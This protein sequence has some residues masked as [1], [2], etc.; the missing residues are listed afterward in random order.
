M[1]GR[2]IVRSEALSADDGE[3]E[4]LRLM[5][6]H[7]TQEALALFDARTKVLLHA[8]PRYVDLVQ[9]A[10]D[11]PRG[12]ILGRSWDELSPMGRE[13]GAL[14]V[15]ACE[16]GRPEHR[17]ELRVESPRGETFWDC[18]LIPIQTREG[19][20]PA[21]VRYIVVSAVEVT[22]QVETRERLGE[23]DRLKDQFLSLVSHEL[24]TPL[25]PLRTYTEILARQAQ[26]SGDHE[27]GSV[28]AKFE[29]QILH[30]TRLTDDLLDVARLEN[31]KLALELTQ[32]DLRQ[33][34]RE[35]AARLASQHPS[36]EVRLDLPDAPVVVRADEDRVVQV[37]SN[38]LDN[39]VTHGRSPRIDV[40]VRLEGDQRAEMEVEDYGV[41]IPAG[42]REAIFD[43]LYQASLPKRTSRPGL[44]LGLFIARE[45]VEQHGGE[46]RVASEIG[47]GSV[48][49]VELPVEGE[50]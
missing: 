42:E 22:E 33:T 23:L 12:S 11:M 45:L 25:V 2:D 44:G 6:E 1:T 36:V 26:S 5:M 47:K 14:F 18:S 34:A 40:R 50:D 48:F 7:A 10:H 38:L 17:R 29:K 43:R 49:T 21:D 9:K 3:C 4:R 35:A 24:R 32:V 8:S 31:G 27:L 30:L 46:L 39:A 28:A 20:T 41:G 19:G 37:L 15:R 13:A 16:T